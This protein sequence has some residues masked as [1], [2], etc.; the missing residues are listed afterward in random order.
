MHE[1]LRARLCDLYENDCIFDK[2]DCCMNGTAKYVASGSY[3]NTFRV[4]GVSDTTDVT[5]EASRDPMRRRLQQQPKQQQQANR[6]QLRKAMA[7]GKRSPAD[8]VEPTNLDYQ[9]KLL[10][11]AWHPEANVIACAASNSLYMYCA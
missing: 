2:F 7:L 5:L 10:H 1:H 6:F 8:P 3:N 9:S 4:F 11:L